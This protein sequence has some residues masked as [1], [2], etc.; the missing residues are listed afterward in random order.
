MESAFDLIQMVY[1]LLLAAWFG[2]V[3]FGAMATPIVFRTVQDADPTLPTILSVNLER[4][5]AALLSI[6]IGANLLTRLAWV[7]WVC[8]GGVLVG[9]I[10]Q[11][12]RVYGVEQ[13]V[14]LAALRSAMYVAACGLLFYSW[15]KLWPRIA[16]MRQEYVDNADDPELAQPVRDRLTRAQ[17]ESEIIQLVIATLLS[18]LILFSA[19]GKYRMST[20]LT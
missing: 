5:H 2:L 8:A 13:F 9:M 14:V 7:Q 19:V 3:L 20:I 12:F 18:A 6:T 16:A 15:A 17:R 11:W 1:W 10:A 4:Q